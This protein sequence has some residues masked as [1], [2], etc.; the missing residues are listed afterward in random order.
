MGSRER[1]GDRSYEVKKTTSPGDLEYSWFALGVAHYF[2]NF[3]R[4]GIKRTSTGCTETDQGSL[5][6][7]RLDRSKEMILV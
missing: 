6:Q 4:R 5:E 7:E 2:V 1:P 3:Y